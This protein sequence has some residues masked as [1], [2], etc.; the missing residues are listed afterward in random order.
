MNRSKSVKNV[1]VSVTTYLK[2]VVLQYFFSKQDMEVDIKQVIGD[3]NRKQRKYAEGSIRNCLYKLKKQNLLLNRRAFQSSYYRLNMLEIRKSGLTTGSCGVSCDSIVSRDG[4]VSSILQ[5]ARSNGF[6]NLCRVHSVFLVSNFWFI[7][8]FHKRVEHTPV[9]WLGIN[10]F[11]WKRVPSFACYRIHVFVARYG[12]TFSVFDSEKMTTRIKGTF[13][14][15]LS[16]LR[17]MESVIHEAL[18]LVFGKNRG[19]WTFPSLDSWIVQSW[20]YGRDSKKRF[21]CKFEVL[22]KDYFNGLAHI[23]VRQ[24]DGRLRV[25][26]FQN[27]KKALGV[28]KTNAE[29]IA[30]QWRALEVEKQAF[31]KEI[32]RMVASCFASCACANAKMLLLTMLKRGG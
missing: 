4:F 17:K 19:F 23:Y 25:E 6:E 21:A 5:L 15:R 14:D 3:I 27:P 32:P 30:E 16:G 9:V 18:L 11:C 28:L 22:F 26:N 13:P 7:P 8:V 24:E 12:V 10:K 29:I 20:H 1:S 2:S 31:K